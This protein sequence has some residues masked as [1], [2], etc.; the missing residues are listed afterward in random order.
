MLEKGHVGKETKDMLNLLGWLT[1]SLPC[2]TCADS[3]L[4]K[5][6]LEDNFA[7]RRLTDDDLLNQITS[8]LFVGSDSSALGATW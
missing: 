6:N 8:L 5:A 2:V 3:F 7:E 1:L 4:V